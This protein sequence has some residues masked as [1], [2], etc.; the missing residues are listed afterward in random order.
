MGVRAG[1]D[2]LAPY[3]RC[4]W[5]LWAADEA[6]ELE[7][8]LVFAEV[9]TVEGMVSVELYVWLWRSRVLFAA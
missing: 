9:M 6:R 2:L 1:D 4:S 8:A 5:L 3:S 7:Q